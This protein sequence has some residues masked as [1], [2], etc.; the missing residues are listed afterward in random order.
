MRPRFSKDPQVERSLNH[1]IRDG[2]SFSVMLGGGESYFSAFALHLRA[3]ATE[4]GILATLPLLLGSFFQ[5]ASARLGHRVRNRRQLILIGAGLQALLWLPL[6]LLPL[7]FP[8]YALLILLGCLA[9]YHAAGNLVIPQWTSLMGD[10]VPEQRRGRYFG[11][12]SRAA[13]VTQFA[14]LAAGGVI[15]QCFAGFGYA[16]AGFLTLFGIAAAARGV[17]FY[18]LAH[19]HDPGQAG[20]RPKA[21]PDQSARSA[22][23][24]YSL[25]NAF[26]QFAVGIASPFFTVYMLRELALSYL[27]YMVLVATL[28]LI[29][30]LTLNMWGRVTDAFGNRLVLLW[31]GFLVPAIPALWLLGDDFFYLMFVEGLTGL[32]W[33]GFVLSGGNLAYDMVP[34]SNRS[35]WMAAHNV[36]AALGLFLGALLGGFLARSLPET[37]QISGGTLHFSSV[38]LTVF[39]ISAVARLAVAAI[40]LPRI[41]ETRPRRLPTFRRVAFRVTRSPRL[42]RAL[43]PGRTSAWAHRAATI[44]PAHDSAPVQTP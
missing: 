1:S 44:R 36:R 28:V 9:A 18:Y 10:L 37:L 19:M 14:A 5:L 6:A 30:A 22:F 16:A 26:M 43:G 12:R 39:L 24:H 25:F 8:D 21:P 32:V 2:I 20:D 27:E 42:L 7:L 34:A 11:W 29:Q 40:F 33:G 31:T 13:T 35:D 3:T 15:L 23:R 17:S 41:P 4:V 38:L